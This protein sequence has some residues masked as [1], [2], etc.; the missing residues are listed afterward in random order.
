MK[1]NN[2]SMLGVTSRR[3][4][5]KRA[6]ILIV[7][8]SMASDSRKAMA[9]NPINPTGLV[10][11][12]QVDSWLT[13]AQD[14]SVTAYSGKCEFGQGFQTVQYQLIAEEL[15]VSM[16]RISLIFCD[17]GFTPDQG[18][19][20]GSQ[21]HIAEF[22]PGGLRAALVTARSAL[23]SLASQQLDTT[24]DQLAVQEG[25]IYMKSDPSQRVGYGQ[26]LEGKR[27]NLTVN[28]SGT[29]KDPRTYTILGTS[30]PRIDL[31]PKVTGQFMYVHHVRLPGM[32]HGKVVRAPVVGAHVVSVDQS[33]V[34]AL[35]GNVKVVVKQDFVG[36]VADKQWYALQA[37]EQLKVTWSAG[38]KL[39][40]Q[41]GLYEWMRQQPSADALVADSGD[42][43]QM[44]G[45][46]ASTFKSTYLYPYQMHGSVASS[47]AVADVRGTG[48]NAYARI[49]TASQGVYPQRDSIAQVLG[50]PNANVRVIYM[51][52]AGCYGLNGA[53]T[54]CY[55]AALLSQAVGKP[56]RLQYT[57]KDE[58][59]GAEHFGPAHVIDIRAGVDSNGQIIAWDFQGW[60]L[61]KGNRPNAGNPGNI[62]TGALVG[63]PTP[64]PTP[65][66]ATPPRSFSNNS[67]AAAAYLTGC[68][69]ACGGTGN[70]ASERVLNHTIVSPFFTG[71]LRSPDRLQNTFA[72]ESFVD[73]LAAFVEA[74]PVAY[75]LRHLSDSRLIDVLN[76][77]A[78]AYQWD[79]RPS[80]KPGNAKTGVVTGRGIA[81]VLYEGNNGYCALIAE[82]QVDQDS[83][84][85]TVTRFVASQDSGAISNPNG[86]QNQMEGGALQ[87]MSRALY[88]EVHW[89][90]QSGT[91]TSVDWR[92]YPVF[93]FGQP[94]PSVQT[95]LINRP[96]QS[97]LGAGECVITL[98]AAAIGNAVF[99]AIGAR[100]RQVP[101]TRDRVL[102]ALAARLSRG[103]RFPRENP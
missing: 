11:V 61:S 84:V 66:A 70:I 8:F 67:N 91:I 87:G 58:M 36:V 55:D 65:A 33:S 62:V 48:S 27:F 24:V 83:G 98:V 57:R 31:P 59:T 50:I 16:D 13:I 78:N 51:E 38:D 94:I 2:L 95:V 90:D 39:P 9:Q 18:V 71:P 21:S 6:G 34:A 96:D 75:R 82:V 60:S 79:T 44:V 14:G 7:G 41:A 77:A 47:C 92:T 54:V 29:P 74:D 86:L 12:T 20:S 23:F 25:I 100:L 64:V 22:G 53:D 99:D 30:V 80:P 69:G 32:L 28:N 1:P 42:V 26:L 63:F 49:W 88:E 10:D 35:P 19:T 43:D 101:F 81:C 4:F 5:F 56:V 93:H 52:G 73:E 40:S 85:I 3:S 68:V 72:N 46:A 89:D 37:A 17:T 15:G 45:R 76:G 102:A 103:P 97:P